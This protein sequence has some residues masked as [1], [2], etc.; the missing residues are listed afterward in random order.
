MV[1]TIHIAIAFLKQ[2][3]KPFFLI[4]SFGFII[5][6]LLNFIFDI[7]DRNKIIKKAE[8]IAEEIINNAKQEEIKM[9]EKIKIYKYNIEKEL[10]EKEYEINKL[11]E[12]KI[13]KW[14]VNLNYQKEA[15]KRFHNKIE[16]SKEELKKILGAN[17]FNEKYIKKR[18][19]KALKILD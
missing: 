13:G 10:K 14:K 9:K 2:Y 11:H 12:E 5:G 8:K 4:I 15:I 16:K 18:I 1:D 19:R 3:P 6:F 17:E 7:Y